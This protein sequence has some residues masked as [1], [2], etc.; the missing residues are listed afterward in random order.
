MYLNPSFLPVMKKTILPVLSAPLLI[1]LIA[2]SG[3]VAG[4]RTLD[5]PVPTLS[6]GPANGMSVAVNEPV[7]QRLFENKPKSPSTPSVDGDINNFSKEQLSLMIA[8]QRNTYGAA[9]GDVALPAGTS[10]QAKM[11]TLVENGLKARGF[12]IGSGSDTDLTADV[13]IKEFW[14]WF[15]PGMFVVKFEARVSAK[16]TI[17][18]SEHERSIIADGYGMN[19]A[20]IASDA[21][22]QLAYERAFN[23]FLQDFKRKLENEGL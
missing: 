10:V 13:E 15:T 23:D 20:Q 16:V 14:G 22:W 17:R 6:V 7:D 3:C 9:M 12:E 4:R 8:R 1:I 5:L 18:N 19:K 21:N 11:Q 2:L